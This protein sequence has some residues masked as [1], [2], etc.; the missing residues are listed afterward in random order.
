MGEA[1]SHSNKPKRDLTSRRVSQSSHQRIEC[2]H[3]SQRADR[4]TATGVSSR[5]IL[6]P[7]SRCFLLS[8]HRSLS[9]GLAEQR[10]SDRS[11]VSAGSASSSSNL[12]SPSQICSFDLQ[13]HNP[14]NMPLML[15]LID[16]SDCIMDAP[17]TAPSFSPHGAIGQLPHSTHH[18]TQHR[19]LPNSPPTMSSFHSYPSHPSQPKTPGTS[20][21]FD[22]STLI[23]HAARQHED[24]K[25]HFTV[26][27]YTSTP[28]HTAQATHGSSVF[29]GARDVGV[30]GDGLGATPRKP[31]D[32]WSDNS[33]TLS[34]KDDALRRTY[35]NVPTALNTI[36][37]APG[38]PVIQMPKS[39][40][41]PNDLYPIRGI[42]P[43]S[44]NK[45]VATEVQ[46]HLTALGGLLNGLVG[47]REEVERLRREVEM[48]K[49]EWG[50][51]ERE[52]KRLEGVV[53]D[54]E[55]VAGLNKVSLELRCSRADDSQNR[56]ILPLCSS[57]VTDSS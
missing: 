28:G 15:D 40:F 10:Y 27:Q 4:I 50:R 42:T 34:R 3:I 41:P 23:A 47:E 16:P 48:W 54:Q 11:P 17:S 5:L 43:V 44:A 52:R 57:T 18:P 56:A 53:L 55:H 12:E 35:P 7:P 46:S 32:I 1:K 37:G 6:H 19:P 24:K 20:G 49:G 45:D 2:I 21:E 36:P 26:S 51:V 13:I 25:A 39:M 31:E 9:R 8:Y 33:Y 22:V 29:G 38:S 30:I 14:L